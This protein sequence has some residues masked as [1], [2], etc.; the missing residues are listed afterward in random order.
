MFSIVRYQLYHSVYMS[1]SKHVPV[2]ASSSFGDHVLTEVRSKFLSLVSVLMLLW[3]SNLVWAYRPR[4]SFQNWF[5]DVEVELSGIVANNCS[6]EFQDCL[7]ERIVQYGVHCVK[8][9]N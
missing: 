8:T 6:K 5:P 3:F 1:C 4:N 9:F 7:D 2:R